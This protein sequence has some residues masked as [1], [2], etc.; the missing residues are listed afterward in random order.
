MSPEIPIYH[1]WQTGN[2][3]NKM[4]QVR[5]ENYKFLINHLEGSWK[6]KD[7]RYVTL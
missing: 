1:Y 3:N 4:D 7:H 6:D 5:T 2:Y